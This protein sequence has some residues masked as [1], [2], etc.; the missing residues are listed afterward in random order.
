MPRPEVDLGLL[1]VFDEQQGGW[2]G[3]RSERWGRG[4]SHAGSRAIGR[5]SAFTLML[6]RA[7]EGWG[8]EMTQTDLKFKRIPLLRED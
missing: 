4:T 1:S 6:G 8:K 7:R 3:C 5:I 2:C